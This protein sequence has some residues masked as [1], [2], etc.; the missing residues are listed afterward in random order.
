[1]QS[2]LA[3]AFLLWCSRGGKVG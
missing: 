1:M 3:S 2:I